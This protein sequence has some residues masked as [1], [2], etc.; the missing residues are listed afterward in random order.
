[1]DIRTR[2][3][4]HVLLE[5][6]MVAGIMA[7]IGAG[8]LLIMVSS[9]ACFD[10]TTV[11]AF[12][13]VNAVIAMQRIV[14]DVREAKNVVPLSAGGHEQTVG[15]R[16]LIIPPVR[17]DEGY[18]DRHDEDTLHQVE[19]YLSDETGNPANNGTWLWR[20]ENN[21]DQEVLKKDVQELSFE[22]DEDTR[23]AVKITIVTENEA[24]S[25]P[26]RTELTQRVVYL[27]NY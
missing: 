5:A 4:G 27:R 17:T 25:G 14:G 20:D 22:K 12:T 15:P 7:L 8:A 2:R 11:Q 10:N 9:A 21:G 1:M 19:Y 13:D 24:A 6:V 16:A 18:Y 26:K 23:R 3:S